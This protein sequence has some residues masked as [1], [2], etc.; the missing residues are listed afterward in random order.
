MKVFA[1]SLHAMAVGLFVCINYKQ[2]HVFYQSHNITLQSAT[3]WHASSQSIAFAAESLY[4]IMPPLFLSS[5]T[6]SWRARISHTI[7]GMASICVLIPVLHRSIK[8]LNCWQ[9]T[10]FDRCAFHRPTNCQ[11][12]IRI[13]RWCIA[14][15]FRPSVER[16]R[17]VKVHSDCARGHATPLDAAWLKTPIGC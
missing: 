13:A 11:K 10:C 8:K 14:A 4:F 6:V 9:L 17:N 15:S 2:S 3:R 5:F 1:T 12:L 16:S 7:D